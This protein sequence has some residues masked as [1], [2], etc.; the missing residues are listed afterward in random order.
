MRVFVGI[1]GD[2]FRGGKIDQKPM[3]VLAKN[4]IE[5]YQ[6][7]CKNISNLSAV[8]KLGVVNQNI[9]GSDYCEYLH[10]LCCALLAVE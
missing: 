7:K 2:W 5:W 6:N 1:A 3:L 8:D 10:C 9:T 4:M